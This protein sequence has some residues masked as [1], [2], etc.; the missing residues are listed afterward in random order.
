MEGQSSELNLSRTY[1]E[2][3]SVFRSKHFTHIPSIASTRLIDS[4][5]SPESSDSK[6][7]ITAQHIH[8]P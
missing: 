7:T 1:V 5:G 8:F 2:R 6:V 3:R 4:E